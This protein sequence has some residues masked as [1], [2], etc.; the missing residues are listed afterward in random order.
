MPRSENLSRYFRRIITTRNNGKPRKS[1]RPV[2][3]LLVASLAISA[4]VIFSVSVGARN[5][6]WLW[7]AQ[8]STTANSS[9]AAK[10]AP[11]SASTARHSAI[12]K[13]LAMPPVAPVVTATKTDSLF[14]D[15]DLDWQEPTA[16]RQP[17]TSGSRWQRQACWRTTRILMVWDRQSA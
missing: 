1:I 7:K 3:S 8:P 5:L 9:E 12:A 17:A 14:T 16:I 10:N 4:A 11:S 15:V 2:A 13:A 6:G